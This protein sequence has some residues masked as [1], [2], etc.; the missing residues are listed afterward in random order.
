MKLKLNSDRGNSKVTVIIV[1][2]I[3]AAV[4]CVG[5]LTVQSCKRNHLKCFG[6]NS[7]W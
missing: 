1:A 5:G 4:A 3:I 2:L 7:E 6:S